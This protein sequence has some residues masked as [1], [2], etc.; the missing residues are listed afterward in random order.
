VRIWRTS[1]N[2]TATKR[3]D[4][5]CVPLALAVGGARLLALGNKP[6]ARQQQPL[7]RRASVALAAASPNTSDDQRDARLAHCTRAASAG[8]V[9]PARVLRR[10]DLRDEFVLALGE[11]MTA[12]QFGNCDL[13]RL[14]GTSHGGVA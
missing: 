10:P 14:R 6:D 13:V 3:R 2:T 1:T 12:L 11:A 5:S 7:V 8:A 4:L 9:A